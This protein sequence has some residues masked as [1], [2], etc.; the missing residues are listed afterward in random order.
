MIGTASAE[1]PGGVPVRGGCAVTAKGSATPLNSQR[2][3]G[4][5]DFLFDLTEH[6]IEIGS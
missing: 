3:A 1:R 6:G 5:G 2:F 4:C